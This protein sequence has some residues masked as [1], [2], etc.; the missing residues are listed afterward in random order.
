[1]N[2]KILNNSGQR[3]RDK[4]RYR[5]IELP[6]VTLKQ[7]KSTGVEKKTN[8]MHQNRIKFQKKKTAITSH[9]YKL[10]SRSKSQKLLNVNEFTQNL[11]RHSGEGGETLYEGGVTADGGGETSYGVEETAVGDGETAEPSLTTSFCKKLHE[12]LSPATTGSGTAQRVNPYRCRSVK[13]MLIA[14]I[15]D[16]HPFSENKSTEKTKKEK[17]AQKIKILNTRMDSEEKHFSDISKQSIS[18]QIYQN[19][20]CKSSK[21]KLVEELYTP[22]KHDSSY[23]SSSYVVSGKPFYKLPPVNVQNR[24]MQRKSI[25]RQKLHHTK[26]VDKSM[27]PAATSDVSI[28]AVTAS[29]VKISAEV[30]NNVKIS[31]AAASD[32]KINAASASNVKRAVSDVKMFKKVMTLSPSTPSMETLAIIPNIQTVAKSHITLRHATC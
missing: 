8:K 19:L 32:V 7:G 1:M 22:Q 3:E 4:Q 31:T 2:R 20:M 11:L 10:F 9:R 21:R 6:K 25:Y 18:I 15:K 30:A 17:I 13:D 26:I 27:I 29:D 16:L 12:K 14:S 24:Q 23:H 28:S 5:R